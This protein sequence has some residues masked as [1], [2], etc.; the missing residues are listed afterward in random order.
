MKQTKQMYHL[1]KAEKLGD[2]VNQFL[3][4]QVVPKQAK[5]GR[6]ADCWVDILPSELAEHSQI[7]DISGG[8]LLVKVDSPSYKYELQ[9]CSAE[10]LQQLKTRCSSARIERMKIIIG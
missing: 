1:I 2:I 8:Q 4:K 10:I 3:E 6:L 9:L 5:F 7:E